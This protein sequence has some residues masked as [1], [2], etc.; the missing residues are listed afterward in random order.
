MITMRHVFDDLYESVGRK[1]DDYIKL[2]PVNPLTRYF[3]TDGTILD[4]SDNINEMMVRISKINKQDVDGYLAYLAYAK[5][6]HE[7]TG[8]VFI[9]DKPP[10]LKSFAKVPIQDWLKADP[11]RTMHGAI[12]SFVK[13]PHLQQLLGRFATYVGGSPYLAPATLN[14]IADVELN[15]GVWYPEGGIYTIAE[16]MARLA[17]ELGV[18]I[19]TSTPVKQIITEKNVVQS[20]K[21]QNGQI[22]KAD[23]VIANV[24]VTTTYKHLLP[25]TKNKQKRLKQLTSYEPSCSGF[26]MLLGL[27]ENYP[28]LAHHNIIFSDDYPAEFD[29][30]FKQGIPSDNPT[31]YISITSKTNT[32]HAPEGHENWFILVNAPALSNNYN[33][34][35]NTDYYHDLVLNRLAERGLDIQDKIV[36]EKILTPVDLEQS[37]GAWRGALY[38]S[39]PNSKWTAFRRPHNRSKD[40][41][42]LY[43]VGGTTHPG[44]GVPMVTLSQDL[45]TTL[46]R[47]NGR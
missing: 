34:E 42:G 35:E 10:T 7:I 26:I 25:Q 12:K 13:S 30:I 37:S 47:L 2:K 27:E 43:F 31:I 41:S 6:I 20:V 33:W 36:T 29:A 8:S 45:F 38:G 40:I 9:Y 46:A 14:V 19:H 5:R 4:A 23:A 24:D 3:Y 39:S 1:L 17:K 11:F 21:L 32:H 16:G 18:E 28:E 44:G 22:I 15:G